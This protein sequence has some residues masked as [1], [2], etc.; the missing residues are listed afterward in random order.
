MGWV[1]GRMSGGCACGCGCGWGL[2]VRAGL[3]RDWVWWAGVGAVRLPLWVGRVMMGC[4]LLRIEGVDLPGRRCASGPDFLGYD[5]VHVG[6]QRKDR[7]RE[8]LD[9]QPGDAARV[10]WTMECQAG[11][12]ADAVVLSGRYIQNRLGGRF[13]YLSWGQI[14]KGGDFQMFRRAKLMLDAVGPEVM[15]AA[16]EAGELV[17]TLR[18][19]DAKGHPIC[20]RVRPPLITWAAGS[21]VESMG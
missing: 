1:M 4:M 12:E 20:A 14:D 6:V 18:L 9:V 2:G 17:G 10:S 8:L 15:A 13:V 16:A 7:P 11:L 3:V 21:T 5:N 19:T